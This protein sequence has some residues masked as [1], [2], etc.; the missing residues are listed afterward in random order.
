MKITPRRL[1]A[2]LVISVLMCG[3]FAV[4]QFHAHG[5]DTKLAD[6]KL[7]Q[8]SLP[9]LIAALGL[10]PTEVES[11]HDFRFKA[12]HGDEWELSMSAVLSND[13]EWIWIMAWLDELPRSARDVPRVAL[14]R[15]T[16]YSVH[17]GCILAVD[18]AAASAGRAA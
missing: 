3:W 6:G 15:R 17:A 16:E 4:Q 14:L 2:I 10:K 18:R 5:A 11:R 1:I 7:T 13:G 8:E 12:K 9:K